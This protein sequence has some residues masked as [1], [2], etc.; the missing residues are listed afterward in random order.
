M[1]K[2]S[3][4]PLGKQFMAYVEEYIRYMRTACSCKEPHRWGGCLEILAAS[5]MYEQ[6]VYLHI[7]DVT[8]VFKTAMKRT[9][10]SK[11]L[12]DFRM[13]GGITI[14]Q[15]LQTIN[16]LM[17]LAQ[18]NWRVG[19]LCRFQNDT[20]KVLTNNELAVILEDKIRKTSTVIEK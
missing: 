9:T 3:P 14:A 20:T 7:M 16:N 18:E 13:K 2:F 19:N 10:C 8:P 17:V 1:L 4:V 11:S 6:P 12:Y 15:L 5:I